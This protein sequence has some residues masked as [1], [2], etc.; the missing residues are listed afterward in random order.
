MAQKGLPSID[1]SEFKGF[2]FIY[3]DKGCLGSPGPFRLQEAVYSSLR[4]SVVALS[5]QHMLICKRVQS[6]A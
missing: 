1:W 3:T 2:A 6:E 4:I 5:W